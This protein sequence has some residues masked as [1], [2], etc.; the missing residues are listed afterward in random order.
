M[1]GGEGGVMV[2]KIAK[3]FIGL[4]LSAA[5][6]FLVPTIDWKTIGHKSG[7]IGYSFSDTMIKRV[8]GEIMA[9]LERERHFVVEKVDLMRESPRKL[10]GVAKVW[11]KFSERPIQLPCSA[12]MSDSSES[13]RISCP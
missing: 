4:A 11:T 7:L 6:F 8:E 2:A 13:Y 9:E 1:L 10:T 3:V 12:V 5:A